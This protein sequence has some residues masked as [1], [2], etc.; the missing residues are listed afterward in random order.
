MVVAEIVSLFVRD[1]PQGVAA[2]RPRA[3]P[4]DVAHAV[5]AARTD[6]RKSINATVI[7]VDVEPR[8]GGGRLRLR[9]PGVGIAGGS[10]RGNR[11]PAGHGERDY[12][13]AVGVLQV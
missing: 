11:V 3:W 9:R 2:V 13:L 6:P 1:G 8:A 10:R 4:A 12:R 5:P 7:R